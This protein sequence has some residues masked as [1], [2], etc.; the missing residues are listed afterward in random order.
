VKPYV[1]FGYGGGLGESVNFLVDRQGLTCLTI[2]LIIS[3]VPFKGRV[4]YAA[5]MSLSGLNFNLESVS[6][7][8]VS[9][10]LRPDVI[11]LQVAPEQ[12]PFVGEMPQLLQIAEDS[13][14]S[15]AMAVLFGEQVIGYYR[16]DF[17]LGAIAFRDFGRPSLGLRAFFIAHDWQGRGHGKAAIQALISDIRSR[18]PNY[19]LLALSVNLRNE[20]A[21]SLYLK[22]GFLDHG[23][24]YLGGAS[25]PQH[26]MVLEL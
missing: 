24:L 25:G 2:H 5:P 11:A 19:Q 15:E 22:A 9:A 23:E 12:V 1:L 26:V 3:S 18:Y 14:R 21:R 16:L 8:P 20:V 17:A 13:P 6:V 7:V 4:G 10:Y